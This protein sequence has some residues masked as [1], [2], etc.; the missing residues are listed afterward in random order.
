MV[1]KLKT[2]ISVTLLLVAVAILAV[3]VIGFGLS[4][5]APLMLVIGLIIVVARCFG[6]SWQA[7]Q[8]A[9]LSGVSSGIAPLFLFLLIGSLIALWLATGVIPTMIWVGF[10]LLSP[11]LFLPTALLSTAIVGTLIGSAFTTLSTVGVALM[12]VGT[13][14]GFDPALIA[15]TVLSGAIFGDKSSPL[16]DSTNLAS[17]IS[18]TD[19]FAHIKNLMWTTLPA[20]IL[21][22]VMTIIL[23]FG[24]QTSGDATAKISRLLP[25]LAPTWWAIVPL[26]LLVITAWRKIPAIPA[27]MINILISSI[28]FVTQHSLTAWADLLINGFK[29]SSHNATLMALMNR[30]GMSAMMP[31]VMM[32]MLALA[33]GGLLSGLGILSRVMAPVVVYLKTQRAMIVAT[34]LTGI[35]ANFLVGEQY[36]ATILP[37]QLFKDSFKRV[38][39]S[40]L[41][42]GRTIEDSGTVMNYL[43]P[44]GVAGAFAAQTLGVSVLAFAPFTFFALFSPVM[45]LL[46][47]VTGIGLK[48]LEK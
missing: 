43:V 21:S 34:L 36:L 47:A 20:L 33:F 29:T 26:G 45:S 42:L 16:S 44:W 23:G 32:I 30:G 2:K 24:H 39:L 37:G 6:V 12:G 28:A 9:L 8:K 11:Q 27:L 7:S 38:G 5:I 22:L 17:A 15:G 31:T 18:E 19:L 40:A 46:S 35:A 4:P 41:A 1:T 3:G 14:M 25:L 48:Q 13:L 10:K